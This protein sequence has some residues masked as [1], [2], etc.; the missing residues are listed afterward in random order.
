[1][2]AEVVGWKQHPLAVFLQRILKRKWDCDVQLLED[3]HTKEAECF[4]FFFI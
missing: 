2:V 1:M 3:C 4:F